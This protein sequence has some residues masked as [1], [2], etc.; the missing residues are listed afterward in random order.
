MANGPGASRQSAQGSQR[1]GFKGDSQS[2]VPQQL[3]ILRSR[4][5]LLRRA[6]SKLTQRIAGLRESH[7]NQIA[8]A[9]RPVHRALTRKIHE[10]LVALVDAN[11]ADEELRA[12]VPG[13]QLRLATF[14][15]V[16]RFGPRGDPC[17]VWKNY[18]IREG[19]IDEN[20]PESTW[21]AA[22]L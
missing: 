3:E 8:R 1:I 12:S 9:L 13:I 20:E 16:G 17:Q 2:V 21:P 18:A 22:A 14:P 19:L 6:E 11:I 5:D 4:H 7:N 10:A 15:N